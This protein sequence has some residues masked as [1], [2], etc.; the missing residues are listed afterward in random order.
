[1][2]ALTKTSSSE[3]IKAYFTAILKL[4]SSNEEFPVDLESVWMLVYSERNKAIRSLKANFIE[5][6]DYSPIAQNGERSSDGKF[7]NGIQTRYMLSLSCLEYF[8]ARKVRPV[9]EVY[10]QVFHKSIQPKPVLETEDDLLSRALVVASRRIEEKDKQVKELSFQN[11]QLEKESAE[12]RPKVEFATS[13]M[14][15]DDCISIAEM[16]QI[17]KQNKLS[18]MGQN[19]FFEWLRCS[20]YLIQRGIRRNLPTQKSTN[21]GIMRI[22]EHAADGK[23]GK[24]LISRKAVITVGG[25]VYF[26]KRFTEARGMLFGL[27]V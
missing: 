23:G 22:V 1:M 14:Q 25:Q 5:N 4:Q 9:F 26:V 24:V 17:L 21:L 27:F 10:R 19:R 15:S 3:E 7:S 13:I 6:E 2:E 18:R 20:G 8:I 12:N 16:A 11:K